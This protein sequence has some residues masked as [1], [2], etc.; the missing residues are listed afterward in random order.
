VS[1]RLFLNPKVSLACKIV[2]RNDGL[3]QGDVSLLASDVP[4]VGLESLTCARCHGERTP[5]CG[6]ACMR[7]YTVSAKRTCVH[8]PTHLYQRC[9]STHC[10]RLLWQVNSGSNDDYDDD[11]GGFDGGDDDDGGGDYGNDG[12]VD[13]RV[14]FEADTNTTSDMGTSGMKYDELIAQEPQVQ[15]ISLAYETIAKRVDVR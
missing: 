15:S 11:S 7:M 1:C 10:L 12:I 13:G 2:A 3:L 5:R 9:W 8:S 6:H 4:N 14:G